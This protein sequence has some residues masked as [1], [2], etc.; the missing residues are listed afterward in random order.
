MRGAV[1]RHENVHSPDGRLRLGFVSPDLGWHPVGFFL[2]RILENLSQQVFPFPKFCPLAWRKHLEYLASRE[3]GH[4]V[5]DGARDHAI[6]YDLIF[7]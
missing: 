7:P 6:N 2:V 1:A 3:G 4:F 5:S